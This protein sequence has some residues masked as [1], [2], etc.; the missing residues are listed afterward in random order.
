MSGILTLLLTLFPTMYFQVGTGTVFSSVDKFNPNP[1]LGCD[2]RKTLNDKSN[3]IAHRDLPCGAQV[4]V[5][6]PR[7]AKC[8]IAIKQDSGPYGV[9]KGRYTAIVDMTKKVQKELG[10]NGME[11]V[12]LISPIPIEESL[13]KKKHKRINS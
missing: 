7:T 5:C 8:T 1:T 13:P 2:V 12:I 4:I 3:V 9:T 6:N 11:P 10:H